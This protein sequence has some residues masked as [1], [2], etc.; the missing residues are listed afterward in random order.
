MSVKMAKKEDD[1]KQGTNQLQAESTL[2]GDL[3][4][5]DLSR[6]N[7]QNDIWVPYSYFAVP[8]NYPTCRSR[9][10]PAGNYR[11]ENEYV[12]PTDDYATT[13]CSSDA[14]IEL[15]L[16]ATPKNFSSKVFPRSASTFSES[17]G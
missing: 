1:L 6:V 15:H 5:W 9:S 16:C 7:D 2:A 17:D 11:C 3:V 12:F 13:A 4:Y 8:R 10:S 14:I